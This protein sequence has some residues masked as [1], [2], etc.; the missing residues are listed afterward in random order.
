[1][2]ERLIF[3]MPEYV[4]LARL[5]MVK[6][7]ISRIG[8]FGVRFSLD[9]FGRSFSS[10]AY[11]HSLKIHYIKVDGSYLRTLDQNR[12][13]QFF[14]QALADIAHGLDIQVIAESVE[15]EEVWDLLPSLHFDA[16][17]GY[18]IGRPE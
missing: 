11:L 1:V 13:N 16:A 5:D 8:Q 9:H 12:D 7:F 14:V 17:Q 2:A 6:D 4:A 10:L 3:E 18:F 15:S